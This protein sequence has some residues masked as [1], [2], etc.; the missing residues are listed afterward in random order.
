MSDIK[1]EIDN[2]EEELIHDGEYFVFA[3]NPY[4]KYFIN[5]L[6]WFMEGLYRYVIDVACQIC[7]LVIFFPLHFLSEFYHYNFGE[8]W[9]V[10]ILFL[11][12]K[13]ELDLFTD[14][15]D[16]LLDRRKKNQQKWKYVH[17]KKKINE[18]I[19]Q[20]EKKT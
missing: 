5:V 10:G 20:N 2:A 7:C 17:K 11:S 19:I 16:L 9:G 3:H 8:Y 14:N 4:A 18:I 13:F 12:T 1:I 6:R 15:G